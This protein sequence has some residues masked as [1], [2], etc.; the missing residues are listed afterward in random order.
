MLYIGFCVGALKSEMCRFLRGI[1]Q[2][3]EV[4]IQRSIPFMDLH[5]FICQESI[6]FGRSLMTDALIYNIKILK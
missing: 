3:L 6:L 1:L 4:G 2:I 5:F